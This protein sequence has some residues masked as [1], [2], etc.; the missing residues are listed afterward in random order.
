MDEPMARARLLLICFVENLSGNKTRCNLGR[1]ILVVTSSGR[2]IEN[3]IATT[4]TQVT[5]R[6]VG[7]VPGVIMSG[8]DAV[9]SSKGAQRIARG[10]FRAS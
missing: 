2:L 8:Q 10:I 9:T 6:V 3:P 4:E 5:T 7:L 1:R